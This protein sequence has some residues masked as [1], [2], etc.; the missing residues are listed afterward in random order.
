MAALIVALLTLSGDLQASQ[1]V[2]DGVPRT[3][4]SESGT[5][6]MVERLSLEDA[7]ESAC[8]VRRDGN[9]YYWATRENI[10][11]RRHEH[12]TFVTFVAVDGSGY[13]RVFDP[14][15]RTMFDGLN[16]SDGDYD[17][18]EHFPL[19]LTTITYY[20]ILRDPM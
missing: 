15:M 14:A 16:E 20:G 2:L 13:I 1:V 6:R 12:G 9:R 19:G 18:L 10:E 17:Y 4:I 7:E 8:V 11:L 5:D 3:R